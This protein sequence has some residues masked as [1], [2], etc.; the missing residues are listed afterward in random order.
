MDQNQQAYVDRRIVQ[1]Y[2]QLQQLQPAEAT[3]LEFLKERAPGKMLD[4]GVG[5]GRTTLHFAPITA[6]YVGIDYSSA[7]IAACQ[8]RFATTDPKLRFA[9]CDARDLRQFKDN[10]FDF[11][12]FSFNGLDYVT[13]CDR[14]QILQEIHRVGKSGAYFCF[15]SHNLQGFEREFA[16]Q[17]QL[18]LNPLTTYV[19]LIMF[20]IT[21]WLNRSLTRD[22]LAAVD[23]AIV[24]DESH[25]FCLKTYYIRP[26]CQLVQLAAHFCD[27]KIYSW[28]Q[29]QELISESDLATTAEMWL[30]YLCRIK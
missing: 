2:E 12:L 9:V 11:I 1:H 22:R 16:L 13:H 23:Y 25:N 7:M 10:S 6:D 17:N 8:Q 19:N 3:V 27:I 24:R 18:C 29:G 15:S 21:R 5:G 20:A 28:Q 14:L 4:I 30:Y 26:H